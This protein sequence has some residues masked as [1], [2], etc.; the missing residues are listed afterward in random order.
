MEQALAYLIAL[1]AFG[2]TFLYLKRHP[3]W[4]RG[5]DGRPYSAPGWW[6]PLAAG[7]LAILVSFVVFAGVAHG[8]RWSML[9]VF[10]LLGGAFAVG[11]VLLS[12]LGRRGER[13]A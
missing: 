9:L 1:A 7:W 11:V 12:F 4:S 5:P 8:F 3:E 6:K 10:P 13:R 2:G